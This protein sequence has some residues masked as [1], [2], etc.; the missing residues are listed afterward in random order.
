MAPQASVVSASAPLESVDESRIALM[1]L[2]LAFSALLVLLLDPAEPDRLVALTYTV[3]SLYVTYSVVLFVLARR[4]RVLL[5]GL[6]RWGYWIDVAWYLVLVALSSGTSSIFFFG[7]FFAILVA[8]FRQGFGAGLRVALVS[9]LLFTLVGLTL[10]PLA[11]NFELNRFLLRPTYL[12]ILGY[13]M[14]SWGGFEITH[15]RRLHLLKEVTAI[16]NPRFG[17]D[18]TIDWLLTRLRAFYDA[19]VCMLVTQAASPSPPVQYQLR[20]AD[21][22]IRD[23]RACVEP[24][25]AEIAQGLLALPQNVAAVYKAAPPRAQAW[26][27]DVHYHACHV[28][29]TNPVDEGRAQCATVATMLDAAALVTVPFHDRTATGGRLYLAGRRHAFVDSDA[30][31]LVQ[32]VDQVTPVLENIRLVD[33][34]ASDAAAEERKRIARDLHD[35]IIQPYIGLQMG[36]AAVR[37]KMDSA[38]PLSADLESLVDLTR[39]GIAELRGYVHGL[40]GESTRQDNLLPSVRRYA[41]KFSEATGIDV[42]VTTIGDVPMNDRLA[43][44]VFQMITEGLSNVRRHT[45]ARRVVLSLARR[46]ANLV[47]RIEDFGTGG[48]PAATFVPRSISEGTAALGGHVRVSARADG[49]SAVIAEIPL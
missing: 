1:R 40:K 44:E 41:E 42:R 12:L 21:R 16:A 31:F 34:L 9:A 19:D 10:T 45:Q 35:S 23:D 32:L 38:N 43:A 26:N 11:S 3:L 28:A 18:Q 48:P 33:R 14:A 30:A 24:L 29:T 15:K 22:Q 39:E 37:A 2:L 46:N 5:P 47:L 6:V 4:G 49:G 36:L 20:R 13:M 25:P 8:S 17:V 7:F 27:R